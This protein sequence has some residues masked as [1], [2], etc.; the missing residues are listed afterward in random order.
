MDIKDETAVNIEE[1]KSWL[2]AYMAS[3]INMLVS[4][5]QIENTW[6]S[7]KMIDI[8]ETFCFQDFAGI[9]DVLC[10]QYIIMSSD[11]TLNMKNKDFARMDA[12]R[13]KNKT[14]IYV[15]M[16][17]FLIWTIK[18]WSFFLDSFFIG[19]GTWRTR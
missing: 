17:K 19:K 5:Y 12:T 1:N 9:V 8:D 18:V 7:K 2:V 3:A 15:A 10:L 16:K 4:H 11:F 14:Y 13:D 6:G